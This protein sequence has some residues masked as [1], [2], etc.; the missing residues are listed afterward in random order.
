MTECANCDKIIKSSGSSIRCDDCRSPIHPDYVGQSENDIIRTR[1]KSR[2]VEVVYTCNGNMNHYRDFKSLKNEFSNTLDDF[3]MELNEKFAIFKQKINDKLR[4][5]I[6]YNLGMEDIVAEVHLRHSKQQNLIVFGMPEQS[7]TLE[8][9]A[10]IVADAAEVQLVLQTCAPTLDVCSAQS[11][12]LGHLNASSVA[13]RAL[14]VS[15]SSVNDV[16]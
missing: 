14:R 6:G 13:P 10:I 15:L 9:D 5:N 8:K 12:H 11:S 1:A 16:H 7:P 2:S 3:K 4:Y